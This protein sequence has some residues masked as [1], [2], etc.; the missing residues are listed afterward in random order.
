MSL[1]A[2]G[3]RSALAGPFDLSVPDGRCLAIV[4]PSGSGKTLLLRMLADLDPCDGS[5]SLDG[6]DRAGLSPATWRRRVALVP[7]RSGWWATRVAEHFPVDRHDEAMAMAAR[8]NVAPEVFARD[9]MDLSTGE[10][11]RLALVRA[12]LVRPRVL[13][14]DEPTGSLDPEAV[15]ATETVIAECLGQGIGI[16]LV[17]HAHDQAQRLGN[18]VRHMH[19]RRWREA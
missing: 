13:L 8:L 1:V 16:V 14:L 18:E 12:L 11:Q 4:G 10:R 3:L 17:T 15:A 6:E 5:V 2:R 19:D 9:A 7:A